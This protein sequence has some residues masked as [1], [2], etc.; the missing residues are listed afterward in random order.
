MLHRIARPL[1]L[2]AIITLATIALSV[3]GAWGAASYTQGS[4]EARVVAVEGRQNRE[5]IRGQR[6][7]DKIDV[8]SLNVIE[9]K[10]L[11]RGHL[12]LEPEH[13]DANSSILTGEYH[14]PKA[15]TDTKANNNDFLDHD[16]DSYLFSPPI[17][18]DKLQ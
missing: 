10:A 5:M 12:G 6:M 9:L 7:E 1:K 14:E 16:I 2:P 15:S 18:A 4:T 3:L 11:V 8:V 13:S 17:G